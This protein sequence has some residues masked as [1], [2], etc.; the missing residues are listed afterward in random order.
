MALSLQKPNIRITYSFHQV[1]KEMP[2]LQN[3]NA[4]PSAQLHK[5]PSSMFQSLP[6]HRVHLSVLT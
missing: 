1:L 2:V 3:L 5:A 6:E 4:D